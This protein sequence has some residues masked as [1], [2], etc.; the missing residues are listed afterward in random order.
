[1][2]ALLLPFSDEEAE[3]LF[4]RAWTL[5]QSYTVSNWWGYHF[6]PSFSVVEALPFPKGKN[7]HRHARRNVPDVFLKGNPLEPSTFWGN[8]NTS[9][10]QLVNALWIKPK[11]NI[12]FKRTQFATKIKITQYFPKSNKNIFDYVHL[13]IIYDTNLLH[14]WEN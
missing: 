1:M 14:L 7:K 8:T 11:F 12:D 6:N 3:V 5:A 10:H 4:H 9:S 13:K 2:P